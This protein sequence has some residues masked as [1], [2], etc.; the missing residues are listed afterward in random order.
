VIS[1]ISSLAETS[2]SCSI[3]RSAS[4]VTAQIAPPTPS[5]VFS[6]AASIARTSSFSARSGWP[7]STATLTAS[8]PSRSRTPRA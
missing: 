4:A 8:S 6:R 3:R 1:S 5:A 2:W 7:T